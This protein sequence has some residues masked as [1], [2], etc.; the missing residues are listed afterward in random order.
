MHS[1]PYPAGAN[2][3]NLARANPGA[4]RYGAEDLFSCENTEVTNDCDDGN[5][6]YVPEHILDRIWQVFSS[7]RNSHNLVNTERDLN[8]IKARV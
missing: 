1:L 4:G 5:A 8:L 7:T 2:G 3:G 6:L